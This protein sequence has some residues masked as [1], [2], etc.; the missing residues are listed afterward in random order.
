MNS[1]GFLSKSGEIVVFIHGLTAFCGFGGSDLSW[2]FAFFILCPIVSIPIVYLASNSCEFAKS[3][4]PTGLS[5]L[6]SVILSSGGN[7]SSADSFVWGTQPDV[8]LD[9][10]IVGFVSLLPISSEKCRGAA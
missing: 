8:P 2:R 7:K 4:T 3:P 1:K 10:F 5:L 6:K 9:N